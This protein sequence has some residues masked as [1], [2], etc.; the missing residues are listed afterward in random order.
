MQRKSKSTALRK[1]EMKLTT[2]EGTK[3]YPLPVKAQWGKP[4]SRR[5]SS[6]TNWSYMSFPPCKVYMLEGDITTLAGQGNVFFEIIFD[7]LYGLGFKDTVNSAI[8][9]YIGFPT[10]L[11]LK[12][13][14][15]TLG[16]LLVAD[17]PYPQGFTRYRKEIEELRGL[18]KFSNTRRRY[19]EAVKS[20]K[21]QRSTDARSRLSSIMQSKIAYDANNR[22]LRDY[23][24]VLQGKKDVS[25]LALSDPPI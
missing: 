20:E 23:A 9:F 8:F 14:L 11:E 6:M 17:H 24:L 12:G 16:M 7:A 1:P 10:I 22:A 19:D 4:L 5:A 13:F 15:E 3:P 2:R 18:A 25:E 21:W